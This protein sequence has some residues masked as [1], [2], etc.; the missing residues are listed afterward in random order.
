MK[1][2]AA[3]IALLAAI[4]SSGCGSTAAR[5]QDPKRAAA[6]APGHAAPAPVPINLQ[7]EL[8]LIGLSSAPMV[9]YATTVGR[10]LL[11]GLV[12]PTGA[13]VYMLAPDGARTVV[14]PRAGGGFAV[15]AKL[16]P[17]EN[18]FQFTAAKLGSSTKVASLQVTWRGPAADAM[19]RKID[20]DP[21][22]YLPPASA[23]INRKIPPLAGIPAITG[24]T[25]PTTFTVNPIQAGAPPASGGPG[26][27]LTGFELTEYYPAL[28]QWFVG[29][30]VDAPG[31]PGQHRIDWLYSAHGLSM[32]G[33]GVGLDGRQYHV[34]NLG[35]GGWITASGGG[36][37]QF[38]GGA[39]A[40][41]WR[42]GG[43]WRTSSGA[44]TFP[45]A[46]GGWAAGTGV[47]YVPPP[48][49]TFA[50][51][52]SRALAYLRSVAVD[53]RVIPLGSHIYIPAYKSINGGWFEAND[54]GGAI[55][56]N[57][58]DVFRPPPASPSDTGNFATGQDV[59]V[60]PPGVG[61]P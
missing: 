33:D 59:Y 47:T 50:P 19:Q 35:S 38:G 37:G 13:T 6:A 57:H 25:L 44:F 3:V 46:S 26:K 56:G 15:H 8:P 4:A 60:V 43:Y 28:E 36:T 48:G 41:Y 39:N 55:I 30:P 61:L 5:R 7:L 21:A 2:G 53:P 22:K 42:T 12:Q 9:T 54:T 34:A 27:W 11:T 1:R 29:A 18:T 51:G 49:I 31:L 52:P 23:G 17:G 14:N 20:A 10:P 58:I 16:R 24:A 40:P 45:L 32:E